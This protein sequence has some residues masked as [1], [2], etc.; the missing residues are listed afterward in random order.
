MITAAELT[1][2]SAAHGRTA[3][4]PETGFLRLPAIL[5]LIP[6]GK[7][8]WW[9]GVKSGRFP[10]ASKLGPR[11]TAWKIEDIRSLIQRLGSEQ[12]AT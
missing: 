9:S 12:K 10:A 2:S 3:A 6:V 5:R 1:G 8:T 11:T 4:L 7:S